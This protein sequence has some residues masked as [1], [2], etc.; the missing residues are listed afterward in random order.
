MGLFSNRFDVEQSI[1]DAMTNQAMSFGQLDRSA[2]APMTAANALQSDMA[3]RGI[4]MMLGGQDPMMAKQNAIDEIMTKYPDPDT[5]EEM[6]A[7]ANELSK[8]GFPDLSLEVRNVGIELQKTKTT[9]TTPNKDLLNQI[10]T[11]LSASI[12]TDELLDSYL[13][14]KQP[15]DE[16]GLPTPFKIG[17]KTDVGSGNTTQAAYDSKKSAAKKELEAQ[18]KAFRNFISRD[19]SKTVNEINNILSNTTLL[20]NEFKNWAKTQG[21]KRAQWLDNNMLIAN[22]STSMTSTDEPIT[23]NLENTEQSVGLLNLTGEELEAAQIQ[24]EQILNNKPEEH[25]QIFDK[26]QKIIDDSFFANDPSRALDPAQLIM[27]ETLKQKY[28]DTASINSSAF[29]QPDSQMW[30][31]EMLSNVGTPQA[32]DIIAMGGEV[33]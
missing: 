23:S 15:L 27:Y 10:D 2:Y 25:K 22:P 19:K 5:P 1:N 3:G 17:N 28:G 16:N 9:L 13:L 32:P 21:N 18:F 12:I 31:Q 24:A 4:G 7:I 29:S 33:A 26:L 11:Q 6:D 20:T 8:A 14:S 30:F